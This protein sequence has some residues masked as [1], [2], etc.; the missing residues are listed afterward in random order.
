M[1]VLGRIFLVGAGILAA[2]LLN[3]G[4][5]SAAM[6]GIVSAAGAQD[7][8]TQQWTQADIEGWFKELSNWDRWGREDQLGALNLITPAKRR[9][10]AGLVKK[11]VSVSLGRDADTEKAVD[12]PSPYSHVMQLDPLCCSDR[13][14]VNYHGFAHTHIDALNH[15]SHQGQFFNGFPLQEVTKRGAAKLGVHNLRD[16][17]FTRGVLIDIPRLRGVP[18]LEGPVRIFP[19]DLEAWEKKAGLRVDNGD[20]VLIRTGRWA[21]RAEKGPWDIASNSAGLDA[22]CVPWLKERG[23]AMIGSDT[24]AD[25][26]PTGIEGVHAPI[27]LLLLVA[28][29]VHIIDNCDLEAAAEVAEKE[30]RWEFLLTVAPLSVRGGTGSPV[31]PI[32]TF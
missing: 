32:A 11:G 23:V 7:A 31:N 25:V 6:V 18:Y 15:L 22:S 9:Q 26:L 27:H 20:V 8:G 10:A 29:G 16:G 4:V 24:A 2:M 17:I 19:G 30:Q 13:L 21:R 5:D 14:E 12:N 1:K 3:S 28:M